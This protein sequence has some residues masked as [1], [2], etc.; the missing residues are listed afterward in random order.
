MVLTQ[1]QLAKKL[2]IS[3]GTVS[4]AFRPG[5]AISDR[6]RE[7]VLKAARELGYRPHAGARSLASRRFGSAALVY[8]PT[9]AAQP[10]SLIGHII[11]ELADRNYTLSLAQLA[12][13]ELEDH[14]DSAQVLDELSVDGLLVHFNAQI[15]AE[16][17]DRI[18]GHL[19]PAVWLNTNDEVDCVY[20]D[21]LEVMRRVTAQLVEVGHRDII[22]IDRASRYEPNAVH[23]YSSAARL[24]G[25]EEV[26]RAAG[27]QPRHLWTDLQHEMWF[28]WPKDRRLEFALDTLRAD[29]RPTAIIAPNQDIAAPLAHAAGMLGL[30]VPGELSLV[31][32]GTQPLTQ[33][34]VPVSTLVLPM[35]QMAADGVA[36]LIDRINEPDAVTPSVC[37]PYGEP[38]GMTI[39][40]PRRT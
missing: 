2:G 30:D 10:S 18:H 21:E 4:L 32:F 25:Y 34:G 37:V 29:D 1:K 9:Q 35:Q 17:I 20:P 14:A 22:Y 15:P 38:Y 19:V 31:T 16:M 40:P 5:S 24:H 7:T 3:Q 39:A 8:Q 33:S 12:A 11:R 13:A 23:H 36:M 26:C 28:D 6:T 27:I